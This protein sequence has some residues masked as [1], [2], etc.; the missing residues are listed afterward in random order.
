MQGSRKTYNLSY[1]ANGNL[2]QKQNS[3]DASDSTSYTWDA[4]DRLV[5]IV[6]SGGQNGVSLNASFS[7]DVF[8][9]RIQASISTGNTSPTPV[10]TVQ[11]LYEGAQALGEIRDGR[12]SHRLLTGLSLDETIARIAINSNGAKD[13]AKRVQKDLVVRLD[14]ER[15]VLQLLVP[16]RTEQADELRV[17]YGLTA[18]AVEASSEP[19][20]RFSSH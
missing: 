1:D 18:Q 3:V 20:W 2:T 14:E 6:Q 8:G 4:N 16:S 10:S 9:R 17:F 15:Q 19:K 11:Y 12:L 7:Y 5:Q 13:A